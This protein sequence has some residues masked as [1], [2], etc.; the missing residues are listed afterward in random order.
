[1]TIARSNVQHLAETL[2]AEY[3][4]SISFRIPVV[5]EISRVAG[6]SGSGAA[7]S[8]S[9]STAVEGLGDGLV[10]QLKSRDLYSEIEDFAEDEER[11]ATVQRCRAEPLHYYTVPDGNEDFVSSEVGDDAVAP[12]LA[13][14]A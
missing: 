6:S 9:S 7:A 12:Y 4:D 2:P 8:S 11:L 1:M 5:L 13:N 10:V 3:I 14:H